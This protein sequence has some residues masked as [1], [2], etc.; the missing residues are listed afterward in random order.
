MA[1]QKK[2]E[3]KFTAKLEIPN[4]NDFEDNQIR[5]LQQLIRS[6]EK[7]F[8]S[9]YR[10]ARRVLSTDENP[11]R[12]LIS[13]DGK[14]GNVNVDLGISQFSHGVPVLV[15]AESLSGNVTLTGF[16]NAYPYTLVYIVNRDASN[17]VTVQEN[18]ECL[19]D[20]G[21]DITLNQNDVVS[22][23]QINNAPLWL[24]ASSA[25]TNS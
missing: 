4:P 16:D 21:A 19:L 12:P 23:I 24:Q 3:N 10:E 5:Y 6:V 15:L 25:I 2:P 18:A 13:L 1:F 17:T 20:T 22:L 7:G 14:T 11:A 8:E 9:V